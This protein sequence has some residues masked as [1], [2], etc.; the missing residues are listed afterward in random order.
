[1]ELHGNKCVVIAG[2]Q[3]INVIYFRGEILALKYLPTNVNNF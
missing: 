1:M 2:A 3:E